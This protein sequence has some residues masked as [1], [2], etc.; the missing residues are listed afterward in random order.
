MSEDPDWTE[1]INSTPE[2]WDGAKRGFTVGG[3]E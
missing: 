2:T 3:E 1:G